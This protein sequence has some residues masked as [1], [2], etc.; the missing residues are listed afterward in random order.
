[1]ISFLFTLLSLLIITVAGQTYSPQVYPFTSSSCPSGQTFI[2]M[3][4]SSVYTYSQL[5]SSQIYFTPISPSDADHG[6][7]ISQLQLALGDNSALTYPVHLRLGLYALQGSSA[8]LLAQTDEITLYP[9]GPQMLYANLLNAERLFSI[10]QYGIGVWSDNYYYAGVQNDYAGYYGYSNAY[11]YTDY[12]MPTTVPY[13]YQGYATTSQLSVGCLDPAAY[14]SPNVQYYEFC[15]YT[16]QSIPGSSTD[17]Q[18]P[19]Q[20]VMRSLTGVLAIDK[21]QAVTTQFG[22]GYRITMIEAS[23]VDSVRGQ[24]YYSPQA[25]LFNAFD[26]TQG[27][28]LIR[29]FTPSNLLYPDNANMIDTNGFS[30]LTN[31]GV[32]VVLR[33]NSSVPGGYQFVN[34]SNNGYATGNLFLSGLTMTPVAFGQGA[35]NLTACQTNLTSRVIGA[36]LPSICPAGSQPVT[37]G[38]VTSDTIYGIPAELSNYNYANQIVFRPFLVSTENTAIYA[39]STHIMQNIGIVGHIRLGLFGANG[40]STAPTYVLLTQTN[41]MTLINFNNTGVVT[42]AL[43]S[44]FNLQSGTNYAIGYWSDTPL[45]MMRGYWGYGATFS[46]QIPYTSVSMT[47]AFPSISTPYIDSTVLP[48]AASGCIAQA[49]TVR[50]F[51]F[52]AAFTANSYSGVLTVLPD[53]FTNNFGTYYKVLSANGT[54]ALGLTFKLGG[55]GYSVPNNLYINGTRSNVDNQGIVVL[56]KTVGIYGQPVATFITARPV[57]GT[58]ISTY[59]RLVQNYY[60][61]NPIVSGT[62]GTFVYRNYNDGDV[63]PACPRL[64]AA[65][66]P[67]NFVLPAPVSRDT[68]SVNPGTLQSTFGDTNIFDFDNYQQG[69]QIP[70][71][72]IY[73]NVFMGA[74]GSVIS[75]MAISLLDNT[76][77]RTAFNISMGVYD[78]NNQLVAQTRVITLTQVIDRQFVVPL[79]SSITLTAGQYT[80]ALM[81]SA[82]LNIPTDATQTPIMTASF[83]G[84]TFPTQFVSSG[85]AG[86]VPIVVYGCLAATHSFCSY[87]QYYTGSDSSVSTTLLYQGF[88]SATGTGGSNSF[89]SYSDVSFG[90]GYVT[91]FRRPATSVTSTVSAFTRIASLAMSGKIYTSGA[92]SIDTTGL[93]F[94]LADGTNFTIR[95]DNTA[96]AIRDTLG[97]VRA[98]GAPIL[99]QLN[100]SIIGTSGTALPSCSILYMPEIVPP[101]PPRPSCPSGQSPVVLGDD[102]GDDYT[103]NEEQIYY[104]DGD[105]IATRAL[106]TGPAYT[107]MSQVGLGINNNFNSITKM[108]FALY[109]SKWKLLTETDEIFFVN[110]FD[111]QIVVNWRSPQ[112]LEPNSTYWIAMWSDSDLYLSFS[113]PY[114]NPCLFINYG[115][116]TSW[117]TVMNMDTCSMATIPMGGY[118]CTTSAP[119][120][121]GANIGSSSSGNNLSDGAIAGIVIGCVIGTNLLLLCCLFLCCTPFMKGGK[122]EKG[123][124]YATNEPSSRIG[125]EHSQV[126]L[127]NHTEEH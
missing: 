89:G 48:M 11:S 59:T 62:T 70:A 38:D 32:Q 80:V 118:G 66:A 6:G 104:N 97:G 109:D 41:E 115:T 19:A 64:T 123:E 108:R 65:T 88:L 16:V 47:G 121:V 63:I 44:P 40:S 24:Y 13:V 127:S 82:P 102:T 9:S 45:Y 90:S 60:D 86:S 71:N 103:Y 125:A 23:S 116:N 14:T 3:G 93:T 43:S 30:M 49:P 53:T 76:A 58:T 83:N 99:S 8:S 122:G 72:T 18:K 37:F 91:T 35:L 77:T 5:Y 85:S 67:I 42:G 50:K 25:S 126:E 7:V 112:T 124:S 46:A 56:T 17:F 107:I 54:T 79:R 69:N 100:V 51:S 75:Q 27:G 98:L 94:T 31:T 119:T 81:S 117:P 73:T 52:C 105:F 34:S 96:R 55:F 110:P 12:A 2:T 21:Y 28:N 92:S 120:I 101:T 36:S 20:T 114:T 84:G 15:S 74:A 22:T 106:P 26:L 4:N 95:Y 111:E 68:C 29:S 78:Q 10:Y 1:M 61:V 87:A 33:Y 39:L 57:A 113:T